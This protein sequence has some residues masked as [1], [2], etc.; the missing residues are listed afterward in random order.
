MKEA[1]SQFND[2]FSGVLGEEYDMLKLI[3]PL[4]TKMSGLVGEAVKQ[5][6][7]E[8]PGHKSIVELG[9]GTGITTLS[10]LLAHDDLSII[11]IDNELTMQNQAKASLNNWVERG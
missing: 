2:M 8:T 3:C 5:T 11:S 7:K 10:I 9:G 1:N 6:C 4:S